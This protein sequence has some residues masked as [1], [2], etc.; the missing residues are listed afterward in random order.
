MGEVREEAEEKGMNID[1]VEDGCESG[2]SIFL[3]G[4]RYGVKSVFCNILHVWF[5]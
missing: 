1:F 3:P 2:L 4:S 5:L